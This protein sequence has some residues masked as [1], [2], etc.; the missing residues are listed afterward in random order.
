MLQPTR[1]HHSTKIPIETCCFCSSGPTK[2]LD[3]CFKFINNNLDSISQYCGYSGYLKLKDGICLPVEICEKLLA[4]H[5]HSLCNIDSNFINIFKDTKNT[6]L[7]RVCIKNSNIFD[8][9]LEVLLSHHLLELEL[10]QNNK[11]THNAIKHFNN[12]GSSLISLSIGEDVNFFPFTLFESMEYWQ[13]SYILNTPNLRRFTL[14]SCRSMT[15]DFFKVLLQPMI[16]LTHLDLSNCGT[17]GSNFSCAEHL[18][19]L[20]SLIL[21]NVSRIHSMVPAICRLENLTHLDISQTK[22]EN[23]KFPEPTATMTCLVN[24]LSHLVSLD[25]SGT[26]L[27]GTG[28]AETDKALKCDIPGLISRVNNPLN[29]L[30]LYETLHDACLRHDI[31]AKLIAGNGNE[32]QVLISAMAYMDR[33][34]VLQKVLNELFHLFRFGSCQ[35][36]GQALNV[37]LE[38]MTKH[39]HERQIQITGSATLFYIVKG[40]DRELHDAIHVKRQIISTLLNGMSV[41]R[42]DD[43]MMR[44]G[45]LTLCQFKIPVD[46]LFEYERLVD[47]LLYS[48]HGIGSE[49][50]VQRIGIYLLNSLACQVDGQ[51]KVRL[52]ELGAINKMIWLISERLEHGYCDDVLEVAWSTMWNVTDETPSNCRKFLENSGMEYFLSCLRSFP[53]KDDLLRNM[54]GLL[55]NVAEVKEL[56]RYL[57]IPKYLSVFSDLLES[58]RDGIEVSYNAAGVISHIAS[59]G[60]DAWNVEEPSRQ[61]VLNRMTKAIESWNLNATRNINYRSVE[62]ILHLVKVYHTPECQRWAVWAVANLTRVYPDKYCNLL[63]R[64]GG[65]ELLQEVLNHPDPPADIKQ[66]AALVIENC[67]KYKNHEW[68]QELDG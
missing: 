50:F 59:D 3:L 41:H 27:A 53:D 56:R 29:F 22:E 4:V 24:S 9:D 35:F 25:I 14:K 7:K 26:N 54:M 2:L 60:P 15:S 31:P 17:F 28:V 45:C 64:E 65:L 58:N 16:N 51:Q 33:T 10:I 62:P 55:G 23:Q 37:L 48:V 57:I 49:S 63:E 6:R 68:R 20:R 5:S 61:S 32:E 8:H 36:V 13:R 39:Q 43:T 11:L 34:E 46:V 30:G 66:L 42:N 19:N 44:N 21:F 52:G 12:Y 38:A 67:W 18:V 40:T 47:V 1:C